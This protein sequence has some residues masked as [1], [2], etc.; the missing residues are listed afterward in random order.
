M[1]KILCPTDFSS[2]SEFAIEYAIDLSNFMHARLYFLSSYTVPRMTGSLMSLDDKINMA[3]GDD[4]K[5]FIDKFRPLI[6]TGI[7]P[8]LAVVQGN[9]SSSILTYA[10][11]HGIDLIVMGTKG[12]SGFSHMLMGSI[13][14]SIYKNS[15]IPVLAIPEST[16]HILTGNTIL[17]SLDVHGINN[18]HSIGLL[19]ELKKIPDTSLKVIHI[20]T[21][22]EKVMFSENTKLL[23]GLVDEIIDI[24]GDNVVSEIK[25]YA[26]AND[27]G[28][29]VMVGRK[30]PFW[31]RLFF[32]T[33][34]TA[35]LFD[36][37]I[38][39]LLLPD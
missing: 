1:L 10:S 16:Q 25:H 27:I 2:N 9:I 4:L 35:E 31:E 8:Q 7:E 24:E 21:P 38:P 22:K 28:I 19:K 30:H 23:S 29:L 6:T 17:L 15:T 13:T 36:T 11:L 18:R 14:K 33:H 12:S 20:S 3:V 37:N 34:T 39:L 5:Y 26:D 32:E